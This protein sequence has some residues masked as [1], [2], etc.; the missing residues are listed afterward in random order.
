MKLSIILVNRNNRTLLKQC[1]IS[2]VNSATDIECEIIV[3]DNASIDNSVEMIA[4][5]FSGIKT[6]INDRDFGIAKAANDALRASSGEYVLMLSPDTVCTKG[7]LNKIL[8]FMDSHN[9]AGGLGIRLITPQGRFLPE[10]IYGVK[11]GWAS[12]FKLTG[13]SKN[14]SK[15]RLFDRNRKEWVEEFQI[16]EVDLL[17]ADCMLLRR[18]VLKETGLF[19]ERFVKFGYDTDLSYRIRL[20]GFKNYYFP[21]TY[22]LTANT[23]NNV[24][25]SWSYF[26]NYYGAMFIFASK[27]LFKLP[28][29]NIAKIPK[30][31]PSTY[32]S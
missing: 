2:L 32:E 8:Q 7:S 21:K 26:K 15:T 5:E 31:L 18:S 24:Q 19:D 1:L 12:F 22:I 29:I 16:S 27:Y 20:A 28:E 3:A 30:L 23:I 14:L 11:K 10:S 6:I 13:F 4:T 17:N 25:L 9:D